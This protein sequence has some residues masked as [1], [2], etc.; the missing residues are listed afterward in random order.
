MRKNRV[1][2]LLTMTDNLLDK[3]VKIQGTEYDRKRKISKAT[4]TKMKR[5]SKKKS[6]SEIAKA[7]G[8]SYVGVRYNIDPEF[9]V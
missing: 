1:V 8:I 5:M 4:I 6:F 7:L 2:E 3:E 9:K